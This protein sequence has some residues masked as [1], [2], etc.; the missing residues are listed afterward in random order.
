MGATPTGVVLDA[1][2]VTALLLD[3]PG[4]ETVA[5]LLRSERVRMSTVNVAEVVDVLVRVRKGSPDEV[6]GRV[7]ELVSTV[8]APIAA[9][10]EQSLE[11]GEMRARTFVRRSRRVSL[12]DCFV[13]TTAAA[14]ET[15]V[16]TDAV[17]ADVARAEG[18][19]VVLLGA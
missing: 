2:A 11:A 16:T 17:L 7:E 5:E 3:E 13:L 15:I 18:I 4:A 12:A 19:A 1:S 6:I 14:G 9:S 8:V 10:L